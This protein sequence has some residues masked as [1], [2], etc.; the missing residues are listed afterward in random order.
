MNRN[1]QRRALIPVITDRSIP[2]HNAVPE[3]ICGNINNGKMPRIAAIAMALTDIRFIVRPRCG[4]AV[5]PF[6]FFQE[7]ELCYIADGRRSTKITP[8][9]TLRNEY[10]P[11]QTTAQA[12]AGGI[13]YSI[14]M[15]G[16]YDG[17]EKILTPSRKTGKI[18]G[19]EGQQKGI[20]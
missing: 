2:P 18:S 11:L 19:R 7:D 10:R 17:R 13:P 14:A 1:A 15:N 16:R 4:T 20:A 6:Q 9:E 12:H 8:W 5:R 3:G